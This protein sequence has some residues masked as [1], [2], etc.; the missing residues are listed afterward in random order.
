M[1][2]EYQESPNPYKHLSMMHHS[3]LA[4]YFEYKTADLM[5]IRGSQYSICQWWALLGGEFAVASSTYP[6]R[7]NPRILTPSCPGDISVISF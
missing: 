2:L 3:D 5:Q 4:L 7:E 1:A 6:S